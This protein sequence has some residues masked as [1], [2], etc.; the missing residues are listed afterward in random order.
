MEI[1]FGTDGWRGIIAEDYTFENVRLCA[2]AASQYLQQT[3]L[4]SRGLVIGYDTRFASREFAEAVAEVSTANSIKTF[5]CRKA[6]PTPV[7]SYNVV[8]TSAGGGVIIT[9][10]HNP[11]NWNGFK[12]KPEYG[13]SASPEVVAVLE[14][15]IRN[16]MAS[17]GV[18]RRPLEDSVGEGT[19]VYLDPDPPYIEHLKGLVDVEGL[20]RAGFNIVVDAMYGAGGGYFPGILSG[21]AS[22]VFEINGEPNPAFPG[23]A[24]PE[25]VA[26]NLERLSSEVVSRGADIGIALDGD[27]DRVG[28]VDEK[29]VFL[30]TLQVF[31]LLAFYLL[32]VRGERGA[33]V[34]SVTS[35]SM[36]Y[37]LGEL[38]DVPVFEAPVGF[39]YIGPIMM[40][41]QA[42]I[43][44]EESGGYG[45]RG[46]IPERDGILSGLLVLDMMA[47]TGKTPSELMDNLYGKVGPHHFKRIDIHFDAG[48]RSK[49]EEHLR[50]AAPSHMGGRKVVTRD[51]VDGLRFTLDGGSWVMIRFS[52]TEPLIRTYA[53]AESAEQVQKLLDDIRALAGA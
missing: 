9:A 10:S 41:Q 15:S 43:G 34:K 19:L 35:T 28:I 33:L 12:Y 13:G 17:H 22:Q 26:D 30:T 7:V 14:E 3:G 31:A 21:G 1:K 47:R 40:E 4:A 23:I 24:Q 11:G 52:G 45:F 37:R 20:K 51:S 36:I 53:E 29:G 16:L 39:K 8:H 18:R 27:A 38:Y 42:L 49:L 50:D 5:L 6:A 25:P 32:E 2:Q 46:H 48:E 44:G